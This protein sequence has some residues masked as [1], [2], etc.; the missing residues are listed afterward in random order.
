MTES[1]FTI[2]ATFPL[3]GISANMLL[4]ALSADLEHSSQT[5]L[6]MLSHESIPLRSQPVPT[7]CQKNNILFELAAIHTVF[8]HL[9]Y[10][11][12]VFV[13]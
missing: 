11:P 9:A 10:I 7:F 2:K 8:C 4:Q 6:A 1:H 3:L 5:L 13:V 12:F